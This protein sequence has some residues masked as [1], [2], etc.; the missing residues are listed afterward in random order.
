MRPSALL[1]CQK[2]DRLVLQP[3]CCA[4]RAKALQTQPPVPCCTGTGGAAK[5]M[6]GEPAAT[7]QGGDWLRLMNSH[8]HNILSC[9]P[10]ATKARRRA[11][12]ASRPPDRRWL[13]ALG[14]PSL[15]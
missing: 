6:L 2:T 7:G 14:Q 10:Q 15:A 12:W 3:C 11:C 4:S 5:G 1:Q 13:A 8:L 9:T